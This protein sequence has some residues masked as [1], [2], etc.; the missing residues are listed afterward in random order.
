MS[1]INLT[2][3]N[4]LFIGK[5]AEHLAEVG[6]T[7]SFLQHWS[8]IQFL[9][10]GTVVTADFEHEGRGQ[11]GTSWQSAPGE[12][13]LVSV[14]FYPDFLAPDQQFYLNFAIAL[15]VFDFIQQQIPNNKVQIKWPN[16]I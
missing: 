16:D 14:L 15:G 4:P 1:T 2:V 8:N 11:L 12:N 10:E 3:Q 9:P 5:L 7:N 13:I 6:S